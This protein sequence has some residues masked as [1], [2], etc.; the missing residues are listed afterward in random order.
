VHAC[1]R[2][3]RGCTLA[4]L[5]HTWVRHHQRAHARRAWAGAPLIRLNQC[6]HP[7]IAVGVPRCT[8]SARGHACTRITLNRCVQPSTPIVRRRALTVITARADAPGGRQPRW[9]SRVSGAR[10]TLHLG[11]P[12]SRHLGTQAPRH[13]GTQAPRH[14]GTQAPRHPGT[15]AILHL[16]QP[17]T[18]SN[19]APRAT[20]TSSNPAPRATPHLGQPRT[21]ATRCPGD[22]RPATPLPATPLLVVHG[23]ASLLAPPRRRA[24]RSPDAVPDVHRCTSGT[25][26]DD[27]CRSARVRPSVGDGTRDAN[28]TFART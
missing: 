21:Q 12:A 22:V 28:D 16:E 17:R 8:C 5:T 11:D 3:A 10:V 15:Q 25:T 18:S 27:H 26:R 6:A 2:G 23:C 7:V 14:P 13:P 9:A 4:I 20:R 19:P 1:T 24:P